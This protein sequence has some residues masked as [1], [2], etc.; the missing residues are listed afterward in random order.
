M[1]FF[2]YEQVV[3]LHSSLIAKTGGMDGVRDGN[4]LDSA[5]EGVSNSE[6]AELVRERAHVYPRVF[7]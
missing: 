3:K 2:E 4:L 6:N 1:I 5:L 7:F